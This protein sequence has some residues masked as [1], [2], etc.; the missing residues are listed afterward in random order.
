MTL[1]FAEVERRNIAK[2][3]FLTF[4]LR[5]N[6]RHTYLVNIV[7]KS[8]ITHLLSYQGYLDVWTARGKI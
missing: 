2:L 8:F 1:I 3:G 6:F 4:F 7:H 5:I